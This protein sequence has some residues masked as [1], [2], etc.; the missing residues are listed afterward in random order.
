MRDLSVQPAGRM[1]GGNP[2]GADRRRR[3]VCR[4]CRRQTNAA[5]RAARGYLVRRR[6]GDAPL[7]REE[8]SM[9]RTAQKLTWEM[10]TLNLRNPFRVSYGT[11]ETRSAFWLRL[12]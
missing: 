5:E 8:L 4:R 1:A 12:R 7:L 10:L 6:R 2:D 11:S 3:R 9:N